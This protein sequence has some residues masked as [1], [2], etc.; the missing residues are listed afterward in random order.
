ME[1]P[2]QQESFYRT[3]QGERTSTTNAQEKGGVVG[4]RHFLAAA[5]GAGAIVST[6]VRAGTNR[7]DSSSRTPA[8]LKIGI[9][10]LGFPN[11]TNESLAK[12]LAEAGIDTVQLFFNQTDSRYWNYN[13]RSDVSEMTAKR[14]EAIGNAY[15][16]AGLSIHSIGVYTNLIHPEAD[17]VKANLAYFEAML[18]IGNDMGVHVFVTEAGHFQGGTD[19]NTPLHF[20]DDVWPR[21]VAT[22]QDLSGMA[23]RGKNVILVEPYFEGFFASAKRTRVFLEQINSPS[24]RALL[25]PANLLELNDLDEM[26]AQ[27]GPWV[28]CLHAKDRK[29]HTQVGVPAGQGDLDYLKFVRL[30]AA[31]TPDAPLILEYVGPDDYRKALGLLRGALRD[32]AK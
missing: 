19:P 11:H 30:A 2:L 25:D 17:E 15:R 27:L 31:H 20:Q 24:I 7:E 29:L 4:R 9:S 1:D 28:E 10:T 3:R 22:F 13:G 26:F 32:A 12:E 14:S 21:M 16:S 23:E 6:S 5:A 18:K 8:S